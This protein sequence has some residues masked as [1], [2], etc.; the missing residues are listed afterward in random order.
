MKKSLIILTLFAA[1]SCS[2]QNR[3]VKFDLTLEHPESSIGANKEIRVLVIDDRSN[4]E[5][6]GKKKFGE[7]K[8]YI[9]NNQNLSEILQE[10]ISENLLQ[11]GFKLGKGRI[12]ELHLTNLEYKAS[13]GF[14]LGK[15][16]AKAEIKVIVK[17]TNSSSAQEFNKN[18]TLYFTNRHFIASLESSDAKNINSLLEEIIQNVLD[19]NKL[20]F[21]LS[22]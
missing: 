19:D 16:K 1:I 5:T 15:S 21:A 4:K 12:L 6:I 8:V 9:K 22:K 3:E 7:Q 20:L 10:K 14:P 11:Q 13:R 2:Y 17:N 18:F